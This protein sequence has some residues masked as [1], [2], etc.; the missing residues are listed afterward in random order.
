MWATDY[1][2]VYTLD[3]TVTTGGNSNYAQDGGGLTQNDISWSVTGNTTINPWR[4]GGKNLDGVDR[5]IYSKTA[6]S[7]DI[8]KIE[9]EHG[10]IANGLTVNSLKVEVASDAAFTDIIS[11]L[12]PSC[13]A[14]TTATVAHPGSDGSW[15]N[16]YYRFTYNVDAGSSNTYVQVKSIKFYKE[17][18]SLTCATPTFSPTAGTFYNSQEIT[19]ATTTSGASIYYTTDGST[20]SSSNGTLYEDPFEISATTTI[21]AI[22][23]KN[24]ATDSQVAEATFTK[25]EEI[26]SYNID[27]ETNNLAAYINWDFVNI[28]CATTT[29]GAHAGTYYGNTSGKATASITTKEKYAAPGDLTFWTSKESGNTT[30]SSWKV[31]VSEDGETW[32]DVEEFDA[33][34][35]SK[36]TWT[37]RTADLSSYTNVY[38]RISY[39]SNTAVRAIDDISLTTA[40]ATPKAKTPTFETGDASFVTSTSVTLACETSGAKIYYTTNGDAPTSSSTLYSGAI[41]ISAT[42]TIKAIAVATGYDNS[43]VAEKTFTKVEALDGLTALLDVITT[44]EQTF[45][46]NITNW[47]V[48]GVSGTRAWIA[49]AANEKGILLY[50]SGHGF[51]AGKKLNGV[52]VGTKAKL[53]QGYPEL[54]SLVSTEVTITDANAITPRETTLAALVSGYNAEQGTVVKLKDVT[55][56]ASSTGFSDGTHT[57]AINTQLYSPTMVDG[58]TYNIIGVVRYD[59]NAAISIMPRSADDIEEIIE[60]G[61]PETPTFSPTAGTYTSDQNV[62]ISCATDGA[63][64]YYTTNGTTPNSS[65]TPYTTAISV[66]ETMTIKAI[67]IKND[68]SSSV[69]SAEYVINNEETS[70]T[71]DLTV[72]SCDVNPTDDLMQW[73]ATYVTMAIAKGSGTKVTNYYP[74]TPDQ[75]YTHTRFYNGNTLTFTPNGKQ[76]TNITFRATESTYATALAG[77]TWTNGT[78][79]ASGSNVVVT[80]NS[81]GVVSVAITGTCRLTAVRVAYTAIDPSIPADPTFSPAAGTYTS[82]QNV[83]IS[84]ETEGATIYYTKDG[85]TPTSSSTEYTGAISVDETMTIKAIAIKDSK[86]SSVVSAVYTINLPDERANV[87]A[88]FKKVTSTSEI[89][90]GEYLIVYETGNVAF[91]GGLETLDAASNT[92]DVTIEDE[93]IVAPLGATFTIDVTNGKIKS[94]S[95]AYIGVSSN[96]N[97]LKQ[98]AIATYTNSFSISEGNVVISAVFDGSTM[99]LRYNK[100]SDQLR[101][102]YFKNNGQQAIQLYK[103]VPAASLRE[104]AAGSWG[105]FCPQKKTLLPE[106]ASF[107]TLTYKQVQDGVP[108]KVFFDEIGEG[109]SLEAGKPYLFNAADDV[110][111]IMGVEVGAA[112]ASPSN[113]NGFYGIVGNDT[114]ELN[115]SAAEEA[116]YK[117]YIIYQSEI[118]LCGEGLYT[119]APGRA[120]MNMLEVSSD[121]VAPAPGRRRIGLGDSEAVEEITTGIRPTD[122]DSRAIKVMINEQL[123]ILRDGKMYDTTGRLIK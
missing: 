49:D 11:T 102:R 53:Y 79:E 60:E 62:E 16:A 33:T 36:G 73:T 94:Y 14:N 76:I 9:I 26:A 80:V 72:V 67:A 1:E 121:A 15:E 6:I 21:K 83:E 89:T 91:N 65:S 28:A 120:Y 86:S 4:I 56:S 71:W 34:T 74:G 51:T 46:V 29:I 98:S 81:P 123:F 22:A 112:A 48:T 54:T 97:G 68:K 10:N 77:S 88:A 113:Y 93:T 38:V 105:T 32:T 50:K 84:C 40:A 107:F 96:S 12:T 115:V 110:T 31:Q 82:V 52:V 45:N 30:A 44:T 13:T 90:D 109:E 17:V 66:G 111:A 23:I 47:V 100:A 117:Y 87:L 118:R 59:N 37:E 99:S 3:G 108:Y 41:S 7:D 27:F 35:G 63:T 116:A 43:A 24:G 20:P 25:G 106:G 119:I 39:G 101:F 103:K 69:A 42:T 64:I 19:L 78:A 61:A 122:V 75:N 92:I 114:Y 18:S 104:V 2:L 95:G 58:V 5:L 57:V 8:A 55:Y 70:H 85:T